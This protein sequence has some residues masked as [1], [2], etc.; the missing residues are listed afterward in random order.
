M[1]DVLNEPSAYGLQKSLS[2]FWQ[3]LQDLAANP[4]SGAR[5]VVVREGKQ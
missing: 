1:E 5:A 3:S 4:E 2:E